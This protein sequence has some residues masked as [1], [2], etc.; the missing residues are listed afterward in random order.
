MGIHGTDIWRNSQCDIAKRVALPLV[1][2]SEGRIAQ[3]LEGFKELRRVSLTARK[4]QVELE[5]R[6]L[7]TQAKTSVMTRQRNA[8]GRETFHFLLRQVKQALRSEK[9]K[10]VVLAAFPAA[11]RQVADHLSAGPEARVGQFQVK[12]DGRL[13]LSAQD[14]R[15]TASEQVKPSQHR[16]QVARL[17]NQQD[18]QLAEGLASFDEC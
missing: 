13:Q 1:R 3:R 14:E 18:C 9:R 7:P 4:G 6:V 12:T 15:V 16:K 17:K 8:R 11:P 2:F 5:L 10:P